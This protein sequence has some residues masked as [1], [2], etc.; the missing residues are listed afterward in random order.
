MEKWQLK[1]PRK[2]SVPFKQQHP[3][4]TTSSGNTPYDAILHYFTHPSWCN[5]SILISDVA[6]QTTWKVCQNWNKYLGPSSSQHIEPACSCSQSLDRNQLSSFELGQFF[7]QI[8]IFI[9]SH[10]VSV[11]TNLIKM[12]VGDCQFPSQVSMSYHVPPSVLPIWPFSFLFTIF[13]LELFCY[14]DMQHFP[15][16]M[17]GWAE[18]PLALHSSDWLHCNHFSEAQWWSQRRVYPVLVDHKFICI[19]LSLKYVSYI[20]HFWDQLK[21]VNA[22]FT[23]VHTGWQRFTRKGNAC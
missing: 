7:F 9:I 4:F 14:T 22:S 20:N 3:S 1:G 5:P 8:L 15:I 11:E 19:V 17:M 6:S 16:L 18:S 10:F 23:N 21:L 13:L 2:S 12:N